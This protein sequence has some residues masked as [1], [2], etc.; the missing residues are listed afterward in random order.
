MKSQ[1]EISDLYK[2]FGPNPETV[3]KQAR[4]G[5]EKTGILEKTAHTVALSGINLKIEKGEIFVIMGLS[6]SGKSTLLRHFNRLIEP[7]HGRIFFNGTDIMSMSPAELNIFRK[8]RMSMIFQH[9]VLMPHRM[10]IDNVAFGL[11]IQK[12]SRKICYEKARKWIEIV[13]LQE[14]ERSYPAELSGGMQQRVGIARA[15]CTNPDILLMDEAFSS[16]DPMIRSEM[17]NKLLTLHKQLGKTIIFITHDLEEAL[18]LG[19][20][21]AILKDGQISQIGTPSEILFKPKDDYV[22]GFTKNVNRTRILPIRTIM[23]PVPLQLSGETI[24]SALHHMQKAHVNHGYVVMDKKYQGIVSRKQLEKIPEE[25][26]KNKAL[27]VIETQNGPPT[28]DSSMTIDKALIPAL[29]YNHD[30]PVMNLTDGQLYGII[31]REDI[32]SLLDKKDWDTAPILP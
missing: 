25:Q 29:R 12:I 17:Q 6:G 16:L 10:V 30:L 19:H 1:I 26:R 28:L 31:T 27:N 14:Y 22:R 20:R 15:L 18:H 4:A 7:T 5:M 11:E 24:E 32:A 2:I 13:D 21:I 23:R 8:R 3:L 9:F